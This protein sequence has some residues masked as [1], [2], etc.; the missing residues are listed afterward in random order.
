MYHIDFE[1]P[2]SIY[3]IG[4]GGVSMSGLAQILAQE[5]FKISGSD[6]KESALTDHL[7]SL[8]IDIVYDQTKSH[9]PEDADVV[10]YTA[11]IHESHPEIQ[12]AKRRGIPLLTRAELLGQLMRNYKTAIN[13]AG[14]HGKTTTTSM[15][16]EI[17]VAAKVDP[18]VSV[19]GILPSIG[20][21]ILVGSSETFVVEACEYTNSFLSFY[22]TVE[23]ILNIEADHLDFFK[24]IDDIRHS[25]RMFMDK[26]PDN[27]TLVINGDIKELDALTKG[28]KCRIITF[29]HGDSCE[30][31]AADIEYDELGMPSFDAYCG[32]ELIGHFTLK[33]PGEHNVYNA[34]AAIAACRS[35]DTPADA[36]ASGLAGFTGTERR[37]E[38]KG[39][40]N[41]VTIIDDYSHHPQE[42]TVALTAAKRYPHKRLWCIFQPHTYTRTKA[43]LNDFAD[44]LS[45]ADE[46]VLAKIYPAR[47]TDDLGISSDNIRELLEKAGTPAHYIDTFSG[48]EEFVKK[49]CIPGDLLITMGAGDV[50]KIG[51]ELLS[52]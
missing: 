6:S 17:L 24:D 39:V 9:I 42:I 33:V 35:L 10:V 23:V 50:V 45:L 21:N 7:A 32:D 37:F 16:A 13:V 30:Y 40:Y 29:G 14:T 27:G 52:E 41:G 2:C 47:E 46:V 12:D 8:D 34:L 26:L 4:I 19:G 38:K 3:F 25:F 43:L 22:P 36:I 20:G 5:G 1:H 51:E 48:I 28:L 31:K 11:A 18:T 44:A 15:I 49:N